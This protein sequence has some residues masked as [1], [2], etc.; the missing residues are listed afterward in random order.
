MFLLM[1]TA[2]LFGS[3]AA[4]DRMAPQ[5]PPGSA[6]GAPDTK[7]DPDTAR[8]AAARDSP[9]PEEI[10]QGKVLYAHHCSHCHGFNM[11]NPGTIS[12]DLRQFPHD[13]KARF[14]NSVSNGKNGRM[15]PWGAVLS[16]D[17][18]NQIWAYILTGGKT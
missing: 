3:A 13:D 12:Y 11:V 1:L 2:A 10:E 15:P 16:T 18:M 7:P 5:A 8:P 6:A 9:G 14:L 17:E 4:Q